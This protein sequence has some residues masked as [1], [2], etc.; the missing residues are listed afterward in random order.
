[1][2]T[3]RDVCAII[4]S[5]THH[6]CCPPLLHVCREIVEET[7]NALQAQL[8]AVKVEHTTN[9]AKMA[10]DTADAHKNYSDMCDKVSPISPSCHITVQINYSGAIHVNC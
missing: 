10:T 9:I 7:Y 2:F 5:I 6:K 4:Q 1:M 8:V 3:C